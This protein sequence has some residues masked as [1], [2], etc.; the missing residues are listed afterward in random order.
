M[1]TSDLMV[2]TPVGST[3]QWCQVLRVFIAAYSQSEWKFIQDDPKLHRMPTLFK[4]DP[5]AQVS[6]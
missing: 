1:L 3:R 4:F 5:Q 2:E 6:L